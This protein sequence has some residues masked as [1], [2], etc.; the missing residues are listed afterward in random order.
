M[1]VHLKHAI[2]NKLIGTPSIQVND[3]EIIIISIAFFHDLFLVGLTKLWVAFEKERHCV[4]SYTLVY[5][6]FIL[7]NAKVKLYFSLIL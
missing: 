7:A 3:T 6:Q 4:V 1:F 5:M 2:E